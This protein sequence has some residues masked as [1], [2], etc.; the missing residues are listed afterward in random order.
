MS[1]GIGGRS[2][3]TLAKPT[4]Y[5]VLGVPSNATPVEIK[6]AY[7][8]LALELHPDKHAASD[9]GM[10][11]KEATQKF[12]V[13]QESYAILSDSVKRRDYDDFGTCSS[14]DLSEHLFAK[15]AH[16]IR[17]SFDA[18]DID[19]YVSGYLGSVQE[20]EDLRQVVAKG[21]LL[22]LFDEMIGAEPDDVERYIN[23]LRRES[24]LPS[25]ETAA[26][27]RRKAKAVARRNAKEAEEVVAARAAASAS[28]HKAPATP[29]ALTGASSSSSSTTGTGA[30]KSS[31]IAASGLSDLAA[32]IAQRQA[33][34]QQG[35]AGLSPEG[36]LAHAMREAETGESPSGG[37]GSKT[38]AKKSA[39]A[40]SAPKKTA[41][42]SP[43]TTS[44]KKTAAVGVKK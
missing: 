1:S 22:H 12:Q 21:D 32:I 26:K 23:I 9:S 36:P 27:L 28:S 17:P 2:K 37:R 16:L 41:K 11:G 33:G 35:I 6:K 20:V 18:Q 5:E 39:K 10:D 15:Y 42:A 4:L 29:K 7:H 25:E 43:K 3:P 44:M 13:L 8:K 24:L 40:A 31:R 30:Q 34:R 38:V 19:S 14:D